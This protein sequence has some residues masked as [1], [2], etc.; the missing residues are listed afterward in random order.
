MKNKIIILVVLFILLV[1]IF[2]PV[3]LAENFIPK[4]NDFQISGM[5]G[6]V[7]SGSIE[8]IQAMQWNLEDIDFDLSIISLMTGNLGG[9]SQIHD[10]DITGSLEFEI[11]DQKNLSI[12]NADIEVFALK[13]EKYLPIK[14]VELN[15]KLSTED[16]HIEVINN[17]PTS[18]S[19]KTLWNNASLNLNGNNWKLGDF[20]ITWQ[21]NSED[22][23]ILGALNQ[24]KKNV[25][26]IDGTITVTK[27]GLLEF[28][29][30]IAAN[31]DKN[32]YAAFSLFANGKVQ[33]GR[34][35]IK[36]KKKVL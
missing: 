36:F 22:G 17:R 21:T 6:S 27:A 29:G 10:G 34:L 11:K 32:I 35:P 25:L 18:L 28:K 8:S 19:G 26:D 1:V 3:K 2:A 13:F 5:Q 15:G 12:S 30:S 4:N 24:A 33:N 31:I 7:W 16:L 23:T 9:Y 20:E 14:G